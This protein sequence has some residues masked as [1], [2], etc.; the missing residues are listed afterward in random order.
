MLSEK[1]IN[2]LTVRVHMPHNSH[3]DS[4]YMGYTN[5]NVHIILV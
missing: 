4:S 3:I 2:F 1:V 5:I